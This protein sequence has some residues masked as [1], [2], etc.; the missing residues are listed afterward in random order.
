MDSLKEKEDGH[1]ASYVNWGFPCLRTEPSQ[2]FVNWTQA[3]FG[4]VHSS[5]G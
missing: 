2:I 3:L 5:V 1:N 4:Y